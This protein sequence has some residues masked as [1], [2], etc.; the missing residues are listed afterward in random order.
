MTPANAASLM[1]LIIRLMSTAQTP[2]AVALADNSHEKSAFSEADI[3]AWVD[4][5]QDNLWVLCDVHHR[6]QYFGIHEITYAIWGPMD[7]LRR[8]FSDYVKE[9]IAKA[10]PAAK[11]KK[12]N[13]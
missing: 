11:K 1:F 13:R 9:Q 10:K 12:E 7:L 4:H 6:A 2:P 5:S 3:A 8:D